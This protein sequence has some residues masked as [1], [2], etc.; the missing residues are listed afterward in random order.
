MVDQLADRQT[1]ETKEHRN[2]KKR[3]EICCKFGWPQMKSNE[4]AIDG[5]NYHYDY[6]TNKHTHIYNHM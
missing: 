2:R 6:H 1:A 3:N 4:N 5:H